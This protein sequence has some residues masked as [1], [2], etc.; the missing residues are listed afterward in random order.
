MT[1]EISSRWI[2][3]SKGFETE[4]QVFDVLGSAS[5]DVS[6]ATQFGFVPISYHSVIFSLT[7]IIDKSGLLWVRDEDIDGDGTLL[8]TGEREKY[9]SRAKPG[10]ADSCFTSGV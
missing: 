5:I 1:K 4:R 2:N 9:I 6:G 8:E 7:A 3:G 10:I